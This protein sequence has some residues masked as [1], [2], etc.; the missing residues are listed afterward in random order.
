MGVLELWTFVSFSNQIYFENSRVISYSPQKDISN[1]VYH[2]PI[3]AHLTL[4]FKGFV[5]KSQILNSTLALSF[6]HNSCKLN[7]NDNARA[8]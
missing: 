2:A 1:G 4:D 8:L 7:L 5:V 6:D 3:R